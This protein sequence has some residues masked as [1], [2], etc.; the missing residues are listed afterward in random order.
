MAKVNWREVQWDGCNKLDNKYFN[1]YACMDH[2]WLLVEHLASLS[3]LYG[4]N[5]NLQQQ[6]FQLWWKHSEL[7]AL[8][9]NEAARRICEAILEIC[10]VGV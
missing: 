9:A 8:P 10:E 1:P 5:Q 3:G 2:A 4:S 7:Y 6:R